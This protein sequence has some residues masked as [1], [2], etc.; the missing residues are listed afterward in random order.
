[1]ETQTDAARYALVIE[2]SDED[3]V[4]IATC[5]ELPGC[6]T[7]GVTRAE[8]LANG[9]EVIDNWLY[10]AANGGWAVPAPRIFGSNPAL[11][12]VTP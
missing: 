10:A 1:M 12:A 9:E 7:H 8:A 11:V 6:Q 4:Y 2:W 3:G 5:P